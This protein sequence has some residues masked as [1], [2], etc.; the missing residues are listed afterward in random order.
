MEKATI[1]GRRV[2]RTLY[3]GFLLT[4]ASFALLAICI[5]LRAG[6]DRAAARA[7]TYL[8]DHIQEGLTTLNAQYQLCHTSSGSFAKDACFQYNHAYNDIA[9]NYLRR[10]DGDLATYKE[11][12]AFVDGM[13][14]EDPSRLA[15][16]LRR[17]VALI[18][19]KP[20][21][22]YGITI[23]SQVAFDL[24]GN[25]VTSSLDT[26]ALFAEI[27]LGPVLILWLGSYTGTRL[28]ETWI[29]SQS[30]SIFDVYPHL[31]NSYPILADRSKTKRWLIEKRINT[32]FC[33]VSRVVLVTL[34]I[35]PCVLAYIASVFIYGDNEMWLIPAMFILSVQLLAT[36]IIELMPPI[37]TKVFIRR[38][39]AASP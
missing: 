26:T 2:E 10:A 6:S 22:I 1:F 23:P 28:R 33:S 32:F 27:L 7:Y 35:S 25:R 39:F 12:Q 3:F 19:E 24:A 30:N 15:S 8:A 31:L 16:D 17:K 11:M 34:M 21:T 4:I 13:T 20:A 36:V 38:A 37:Q 9:L 14:D 29:I 18:V 5:G